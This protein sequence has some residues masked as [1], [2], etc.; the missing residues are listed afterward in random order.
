MY[1]AFIIR[2]KEIELEDIKKKSETN[3]KYVKRYYDVTR[4]ALI[5][6]HSKR[7]NSFIRRME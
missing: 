1:N 7:I 2:K 5:D 3:R 4:P 6:N